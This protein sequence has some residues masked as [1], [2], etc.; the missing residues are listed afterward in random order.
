MPAE[1]I[2]T[3]RFAVYSTDGSNDDAKSIGSDRNSFIFR[4]HDCTDL[5]E[6]QN[7]NGKVLSCSPIHSSTTVDKWGSYW[8]RRERCCCFWNF[9]LSVALV[10]TVTVVILATKGVVLSSSSDRNRSGDHEDK[11]LSGYIAP[12]DNRCSNESPEPKVGHEVD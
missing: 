11:G 6:L 2:T 5:T 3:E 9:L 12:I 4:D 7:I 10:M 8:S 1:V